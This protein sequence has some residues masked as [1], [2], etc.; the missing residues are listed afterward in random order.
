M[1]LAIDDS[2]TTSN[3]VDW[4]GNHIAY[5]FGGTI[6]NLMLNGTNY[7]Y[8]RSEDLKTWIPMT[9][10]V[11][12]WVSQVNGMDSNQVFITYYDGQPCTTNWAKVDSTG[13]N[14]ISLGSVGGFAIDKT[15][16]REFFKLA[17][18]AASAQ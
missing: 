10:T 9:M 2:V 12:G 5:A 8:H 1:E 6:T 16:Q 4:Q 11:T 3:W 15:K 13:T 17:R 18:I 14:A 7:A